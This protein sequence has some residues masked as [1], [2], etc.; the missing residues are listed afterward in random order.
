M[1]QEGELW[2]MEFN[3]LVLLFDSSWEVE[4]CCV[5]GCHPTNY[6]VIRGGIEPDQTHLEDSKSRHLSIVVVKYLLGV[7]A[8]APTQRWVRL[9]WDQADSEI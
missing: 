5:F 6:K 4:Y 1:P 2:K 7:N 8:V 3:S 9:P